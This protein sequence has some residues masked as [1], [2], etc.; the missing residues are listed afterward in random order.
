MTYTFL[1][2]PALNSTR[3]ITYS[4]TTS[5]SQIPSPVISPIELYQ[6]FSGLA[7]SNANSPVDGDS[8]Y[9]M[10][11]HMCVCM[12]VHVCEYVCACV[13]SEPFL[14][15]SFVLSWTIHIHA[16][17]WMHETHTCTHIHV[18]MHTHAH[19][20]PYIECII[21]FTIKAPGAAQVTVLRE[22]GF[23]CRASYLVGEEWTRFH[24]IKGLGCRSA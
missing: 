23:L 4:Y 11:M 10:L 19:T 21:L 3:T 20:H 16:Y 12:H 5:A 8:S 22:T 2:T 14:F 1:T 6:F 18:H 24:L 13:I 15:S 7:T 17:K 9:E